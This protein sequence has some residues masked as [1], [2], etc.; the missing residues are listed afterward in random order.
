MT[1]HPGDFPTVVQKGEGG[2]VPVPVYRLRVVVGT[3]LS[4]LA[5]R[6]NSGALLTSEGTTSVPRTLRHG[7]GSGSWRVFEPTTEHR[8]G[9]GEVLRGRSRGL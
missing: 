1:L 6:E 9:M 3:S 2:I 8:W 4:G 5:N 7:R